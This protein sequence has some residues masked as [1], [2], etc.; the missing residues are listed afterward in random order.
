M[1]DKSKST[2]DVPASAVSKS[3]RERYNKKKLSTL[4]EQEDEENSE[5]NDGKVKKK[6]GNTL[7][8]PEPNKGKR[9]KSTF[10]PSFSKNE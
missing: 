5:D 4:H 9:S 10:V 8:V 6:Y 2:K 3:K 7:D 1:K